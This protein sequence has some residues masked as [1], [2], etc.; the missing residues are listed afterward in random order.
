LR[1]YLIFVGLGFGMALIMGGGGLLVLAIL[2][3]AARRSLPLGVPILLRLMTGGVSLGALFAF[4]T[5]L[6]PSLRAVGD[7]YKAAFSVT[8]LLALTAVIFA[9]RELELASFKRK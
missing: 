1:D 9:L 4:L 2:R 5:M 8:A 6:G 3:L 7:P